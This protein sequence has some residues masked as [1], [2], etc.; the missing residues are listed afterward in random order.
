ML[1]NSW[2]SVQ[3]IFHFSFSVDVLLFCCCCCCLASLYSILPI[4]LLRRFYVTVR[5]FRRE[6][7]IAFHS[8]NK[9]KSKSYLSRTWRVKWASE[10]CESMRASLPMCNSKCMARWSK[11]YR[12]WVVALFHYVQCI[13]A[14]TR[15]GHHAVYAIN[16][17]HSCLR[18]LMTPTCTHTTNGRESKDL[19]GKREWIGTV[20]DR[21][22]VTESEIASEWMNG[23]W[24]QPARWI[25]CQII[26][27][28]HQQC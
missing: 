22:R 21:Q 5:H 19:V 17:F 11:W 9:C 6:W 8:N 24:A 25:V 18:I 15:L 13:S 2:N 10:Q 23:W 4:I 12:L 16:S 28:I 27:T 14:V 1:L 20:N 3:F 26:S 7:D